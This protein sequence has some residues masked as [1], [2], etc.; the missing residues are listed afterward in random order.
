M[1]KDTINL[2]TFL[3]P[4]PRLSRVCSYDEIQDLI[5]KD[6]ISSISLRL[7]TP[8]NLKCV[9]C[10]SIKEKF[11]HS[12][13]SGEYLSFYE[14]TSLI[15][16]AVNIGCRHVSIVGD[17]EPLL[18]RDYKTGKNIYDLAEIIKSYKLSLTIFSNATVLN[19]QKARK[20]AELGVF[21]VAKQN[22]ANHVVQDMLAGKIGASEKLE[23]GISCLL[24]AGFADFNDPRMAIH[25]IICKQNYPEIPYLWK[26]WRS[27]GII[28]YVQVW[29]PHFSDNNL[30]DFKSNF[31]ISPQEIRSL[32]E[33]LE[34]I[35][36]TEFGYFWDTNNTYPI[37]AIG[38]SVVLSGCGICPNG[39][40][41]LCAY[42]ER[43][44]GNIR[45]MGLR[46]IME[47]SEV[48]RIRKFRYN[49]NHS[50]NYGCRALTI[51]MTGDRFAK[52]PVKEMFE[53]K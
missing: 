9:Y 35:D 1:F 34:K 27:L 29:V 15:Q 21:F 38:C 14:I 41:N 11:T 52:D 39:D 47:S 51:N 24:K 22:S 49:D 37:A 2:R 44:L 31:Y 30:N 23:K 19:D 3:K 26:K 48:R 50:T 12:L 13:H 42:T 46:K 20:L 7:P 28:P 45:K 4:A 32:F 16:Q 5:E 33:T 18:Y 36:E 6:R 25:T 53:N 40:V 17:G 10:Y 43:P 8:C